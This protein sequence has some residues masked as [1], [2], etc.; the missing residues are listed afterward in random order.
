M[1]RSSENTP[2]PARG[3]KKALLFLIAL[4]SV[5]G[6]VLPGETPPFPP[7]VPH[8]PA[9]QLSLDRVEEL[10]TRET[11]CP[12]CGFLVRIPEA[13]KLMFPT[14]RGGETATPPWEMHA[15]ER[16]SDYCP[17]P[18]KG[19]IDFQA[20]IAVCPSCGY[21]ADAKAFDQPLPGEFRDWAL[22]ALKPNMRATQLR[23]LGKRGGEMT[24]PEIAAF[25]NRQQ[26]IPD[27]IRTEHARIIQAA[28]HAP[29]LARAE[30]ALRSAWACRRA[31]GKPPEGDFLSPRAGNVLAQ[32]G[33]NAKKPG[34][35]EQRAEALV[36]LLTTRDRDG[37]H[38]LNA[39]ERYAG[40]MM[41]AGLFDR[42]GLRDN[43]DATLSRMFVAAR[44]RFSRS[45]QDPLWQFTAGR[46]VSRS[47]RP[48]LLE[49]ARLEIEQEI[50]ARL[51]LLSS[52]RDYLAE[53]AGFIKEAL[54]EGEITGADDALHHAYLIAEL[55][56]RHGDLPLAAEWFKAVIGLGDDRVRAAAEKQLEETTRQ[57]ADS[58]NLLAAIGQ[59]GELIEKVR[60]ICNTVPSDKR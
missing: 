17:H 20:D 33:K 34:G 41:L 51:A 16:D 3:R 36:M 54:L 37:N 50:S 14:T 29:K 56:R 49:N 12:V 30:M 53:A 60:E 23:L 32:I 46:G 8:P 4:V 28:R 59:D 1:F 10:P 2:R 57:A 48:H 39:A 27:R 38:R 44:E 18:G 55:H 58:V 42:Q 9:R 26:D 11:A 40:G 6:V 47:A 35:L 52:E 21:A 45:E 31:L 19:M 43:A 25:F 5:A 15:A 24:E 7:G 22:Q 13:D